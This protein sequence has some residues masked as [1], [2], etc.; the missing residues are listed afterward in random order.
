MV[1]SGSFWFALGVVVS[2]WV[3][4]AILLALR[5]AG[6]SIGWGFQLQSPAFVVLM[7][8]LFVAIGLNFSGVFEI[9][10]RVTQLG[11]LDSA[12]AGE[13]GHWGAFGSGALAVLVATP[14]T[15]PFMGSALGFTLSQPAVVTMAVFT[16]LGVGMALPYLLL[17]VF[18]GWLRWLPRPGRWMETLK[19]LLAF[20][21]FAAAAWLT[22]V[23]GRQLDADAVLA[24]TMGAVV[25]ASGLWL[26]GREVQVGRG[27]ARGL[28]AVLAGLLVVGGIALALPMGDPIVG[29]Q[30]GRQAQTDAVTAADWQPWAPGVVEQALAAGRPV[31]VDFTAA[32]CVSCQ[33]NKK[34]VFET[35]T[36]RRQMADQQ[37]RLVRADWTQRDPAIT[38]EL[39]RHGRNSVPLYLLYAPDGQPPQV[40]PELMTVSIMQEALARLP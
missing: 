1:R 32:W 17:G 6:E 40:L 9:G 16:A 2:F 12:P 13:R 33:V 27:R 21:M 28:A 5:G 29:P 30:A 31:F 34:L 26:W 15:A 3:L 7:A 24:L 20:P 11:S 37:V 35:D 25:L 23:L 36:I 18:P 39:A 4:A 22:W 10:T 8:L 38:A 19:Q 14:C